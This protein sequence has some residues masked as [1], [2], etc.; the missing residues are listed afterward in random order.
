MENKLRAG[1]I[2]ATGMVGQRFIT[3]LAEHPMFEI[4][5]LAASSRSAGKPYEEAVS[6]KW[7]MNAEIPEKVKNMKV[8]DAS[9]V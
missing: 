9:D 3:L 8:Y 1:I 7:K 6:G 5:V 4:S 2:G